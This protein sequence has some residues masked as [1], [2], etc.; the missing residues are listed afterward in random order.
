MHEKLGRNAKLEQ[1]PGAQARIELSDFHMWHS[2]LPLAA[3]TTNHLE[4]A[5]LLSPE[6]API[7]V[8]YLSLWRRLI[9]FEE[10]YRTN[11]HDA[12]V[13]VDESTATGRSVS[14]VGEEYCMQMA[15][16][17]AAICTLL[18]RLAQ[19]GLDICHYYIRRKREWLEWDDDI[20]LFVCAA[21]RGHWQGPVTVPKTIA[22]ALSETPHVRAFCDPDSKW[23]PLQ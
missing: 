21:S 9:V 12:I 23:A 19:R 14:K 2:A 8:D 7:V 22:A 11:F 20:A 6:S 13:A 1:K 18:W 17:S 3:P 16:N 15:G 10:L 4:V 5:T